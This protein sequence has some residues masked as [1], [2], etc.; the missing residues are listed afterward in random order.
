MPRNRC[1]LRI[2]ANGIVNLLICEPCF[3]P[4]NGS[5]AMSQFFLGWRRKAGCALL[6]VAAVFTCGLTRS[7]ITEDSVAVYSN[8]SIVG[9]TSSVKGITWTRY[10]PYDTFDLRLR[11]G[12]WSYVRNGSFDPTSDTFQAYNVAWRW[13]CCGFDF[14]EGSDLCYAE[15][16]V[17]W[18]VP[19]WSIVIPLTLL[20]AYLILHPGNRKAA[21]PTQGSTT[22]TSG[23]QS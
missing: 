5:D 22:S 4:R 23:F 10:T 12:E 21:G 11:N 6:V 15:R 1:L 9:F 14:G 8:D 7:C 13:R 2:C 19:Y 18:K 20:S 16:F 3:V 17:I